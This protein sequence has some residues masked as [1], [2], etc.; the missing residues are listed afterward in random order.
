MQ[1]LKYED[2]LCTTARPEITGYSER[3]GLYS[4]V[5]TDDLLG[6][7]SITLGLESQQSL[8]VGQRI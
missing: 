2:V 6:Y 7:K 1:L 3:S 8:T 4:A 5:V